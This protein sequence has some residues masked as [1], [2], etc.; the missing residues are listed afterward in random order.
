MG[1]GPSDYLKLGDWNATCSYCGRK[2]KASE[3]VK[4]WQGQYR[5]AVHNEARHPQEFVR[6]KPEVITVPWAQPPQDFDLQICTFNGISAIPDAAI[7]DCSLPDRETFDP[8]L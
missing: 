6:A 1:Y 4:N 2:R 8:S 7:P 3:L 5:C